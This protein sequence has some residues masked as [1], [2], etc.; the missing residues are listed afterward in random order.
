[1]KSTKKLLALLMAVLMVMGLAT[2]AMAGSITNETDRVYHAYQI[3]KGTQANNSVQLGD[4]EWGTGI[5]SEAFLAALKNSDSFKVDGKNVFDECTTAQDVADKLNGKTDKSDFAQAFANLAEK[6]RTGDYTEIGAK[7]IKNDLAAGYYLLIDQT[8]VSGEN[9]AKNPALLQVTNDNDL[10][11]TG[12][13]GVPTIDKTIQDEGEAADGNIGDT[14]TFVLKATMP[15]TFEGYETY[16]V[17][18][19]DTLSKGL[20]YNESATVSVN[21]FTVTTKK[22][23]DGTTEITVSCDNVLAQ[24]VKPNDVIT[25]TYTATL[26]KD[27]VIGS[28]GN[29]NT[30]YLEYSNDPNSSGEGSTGKTPPDTVVVFT[31]ELD[32]TKVDG[33]N[34]NMVLQNAEFVLLNTDKT[35]VATFKDGKLSG[36]ADVPTAGTDGKITWNADMILKSSQAGMIS[37]VGLDAGTY[38][39]KEI[40]APAG[41]NLLKDPIKVVITAGITKMED[42]QSLDSLTIAVNDGTPTNGTVQTG[43]VDMKVENNIGVTL[44]ETGGMGT[45]VFYALGGILVAAA[46]VLLVTKRRM[47]AAE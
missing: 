12:K 8:V 2:T 21:G 20:T 25:V 13:Y 11:I 40:K 1:M 39:L 22:N 18:F 16:K 27:A 4:V 46:V 31:Y 9:N 3:F 45:T 15:S 7:A 44:P 35:K 29:P 19:H 10:H 26:N 14:F 32:V 47:K 23:A 37:I 42:K 28:E 38:Y 33:K 34:P 6:H 30:V 17:V 36:W 41:Y 5:N 24:N 43:K